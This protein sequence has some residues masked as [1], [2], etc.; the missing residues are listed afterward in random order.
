MGDVARFIAEIEADIR[1]FERDIQRAI[2]MAKS[3]PDDIKVEI[4]ASINEFK[5]KLLTAEAM[6]KEFDGKQFTAD[7]KGDTRDVIKDIKEVE[8]ILQKLGATQ[9]DVLVDAETTSAL[10]DLSFVR[11]ILEG[12]DKAKYDPE[13]DVD[14]SE[15]LAEIKLVETNLNRLTDVDLDLDIE[16]YTDISKVL[17]KLAIVKTELESIDHKRAKAKV[18][19]DTS[20]FRRGLILADKQ[21]NVFGKKMDTLA[22]DIRTTGTVFANMIKGTMLSSISILVPAIASLVPALMAVLNAV[23]VVGGGAVGL[24]NAFGIAGAGVVGF[25]AMAVSALKMVENGTLATTKEVNNYNDALDDLQSAWQKVVQ[26]NQAQIFNTLANAVNTAQ[27]ALKGLTPFLN[28]VSQGMETASA[29]VLD[30]AKNSQTASKFFDMMGTTGVRIFNNMLSAAGSFGSGLVAVLTNLAPLT[31]W[32]SKG[33]SNMGKRFN[34]WAN[35]IEGS[36]AIQNFT[37]YVQR[38]LPLIGQIFGS[39]FRGIFNLMKAFAPNSELIFQSLA[40]MAGRFEAW[41][42]KIAKSDGF[43]KFIDYVQQNGPLLIQTLGNIINIIINVATAMAPFASAVL[44]VVEAFTQ[45]LAKV[46]EAHPAIGILLGVLSVLGGAFMALYPAITFVKEVILPLISAFRKFIGVSSLAQSAIGLVSSAFGLISAPVLIAIGVI[47]ALVGIIVYLWKTNENFRNTVINAWNS[48][49]EGIGN[50]IEG[51]KQWLSDLFAKVNETIQPILPILQRL[52]DFA[53]Q[54]LGVLFGGAIQLLL[55]QL[56][57]LWTMVQVVFTAIGTI[58]SSVI[59]LIV[60]LF[61]ALIQFLTGDVSGAWQTLQTTISNV[62]ESIWNGIQSIWNTIT[63]FLFDCYSKI[64]G[65]T[66]SSWSQIWGHTTRFLSNIWNSVSSWFTR[67]VATV[68][69]KMVGALSRIISTG[70]QWVNSIRQTMANFLNAVVQKFFEVVNACRNGMDRAVSAIRNFFGHFS[71]VGGY[72]MKG[73][74]NGIRAGID[75]VVNAARNVAQSAVN[76]AKRALGIKSPSRV[77]M[78]IGHFT[79]EGLAIGIHQMTSDVVGEVVNM[80]EQMERAYAPELN[81]I[82]ATG[83]FDKDLRAISR[84]INYT[85]KDD[86]EFG[87][88][89]KEPAYIYLNL[90]GNEF[91]T[92]A[93]NIRTTSNKPLNL[94]E[95]YDV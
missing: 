28:G 36:K 73:L 68:G 34:E 7:I 51:I 54:A 94:K 32:V 75:W 58:I 72:L 53:N 55:I 12:L 41:S 40:N 84:N 42:A 85:I 15:A 21:L 66:V 91:Q 38:N 23:G 48:I 83:S 62:G 95:V 9:T 76:A 59:Q 43:Q 17:S 4:D 86:L 63:Q 69:A 93:D 8:V 29:K 18:D 44:K 27:V 37:S 67:V 70:F 87:V 79:G 92:H 35:S 74:A 26:G 5:A 49:K 81:D 1:D 82:S 11:Q 88:E 52:G 77:F 19:I 10:I 57:G 24:A 90:G 78:E 50:A 89:G 61:T 39:T 46:T 6:A 30:W 64:T 2:A 33:F 45:W 31:E 80:A 16:V 25:G 14:I 71:N 22:N 47:T 3:L 56:Q 20:P 65:K 60:G 13:I